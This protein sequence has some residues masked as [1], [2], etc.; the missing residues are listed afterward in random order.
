M[1]RR[2][3]PLYLVVFFGFFAY[4]VIIPIFT[5]LILH[6]PFIQTAR[7]SLEKR[8]VF[9]GIL[10]AVY[11]LGQFIGSPIIGSFSDKFG[12]KPI[13]VFTLTTALICYFL[14]GIA[15]A[16]KSYYLAVILLFIAGLCESNIAIAQSAISDICEPSEKGKYFGHLYAIINLSFVIGPLIGA[17]LGDAIN[18]EVPFYL[19]ALMF[20]LT[21]VV[22]VRK[23]HETHAENEEE[24]ITFFSAFFNIRNVFIEKEFRKNYMIGF[25]IA[26]SMI[27]FFR[28]FPMLFS[29]YFDSSLRQVGMFMGI[30]AVPIIGINTFYIHPLIQAFTERKLAIAST[31]GFAIIMILFSFISFNRFLLLVGVVLAASMFAVAGP[32][33]SIMLSHRAGK[34]KQGRVMGNYTSLWVGAQVP[35]SFLGVYLSGFEFWIPL[36]I[37]AVATLFSSY[38]ASQIPPG[39]P[40]QQA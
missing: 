10:L 3:F 28:T 14:V 7:L 16:V 22:V 5:H 37:F 1:F 19:I 33:S 39:T 23:F 8:S 34:A 30:A 9:L 12:R 26:F 17:Y 15:I 6:T 24:E 20:L 35:G 11:P 38:V 27:G 25:L 40:S 13:L 32:C 31:F 21:I 18:L 4:T 2:L 29:Y 36:M